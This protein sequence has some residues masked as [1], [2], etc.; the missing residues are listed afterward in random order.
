MQFFILGLA[1]KLLIADVAARAINPLFNAITKLDLIT[2]WTA[3]L[4]YSVQIY[5]DFSGYS[6]MAVGLGL[7]L[8]FRFPQNFN[9][10]YKSLSI[11]DFWRRWHI[12]LSSWLRD[13]LYF[14]LG[15]NRK[16][17]A[18]TLGAL[19]ITMFLGGLWHGA[20]W[21]FVFW[22]LYHG[23]LLI[24]YHAWKKLSAFQLPVSISWALTFISVLIGWAFFRA[25]SFTDAFHI[26]QC[27]I[28][29]NGLE[30]HNLIAMGWAIPFIMGSLIL[31][32]I[33]ATTFELKQDWSV[34]K[35]CLLGALLALCILRFS[36]TSP[37]LYFQF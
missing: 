9:A 27:M 10:P 21:T 12:S 1:K 16:G 28:G 34:R 26:L 36:A 22:G 17:T 29:F 37:F 25:A 2:S 13:Y 30:F 3:I 32:V 35:G 31:S 15:G 6:D 7:I 18:R 5:F 33:G 23:M 14:S 11:S 24:I 20:S 8:G 4:G 19:A